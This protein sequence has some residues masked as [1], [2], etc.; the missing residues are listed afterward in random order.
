[1]PMR[2]LARRSRTATE[3]AQM[4]SGGEGGGDGEWEA[5]MVCP[6]FFT[7]MVSLFQGNENVGL[8][9]QFPS[10]CQNFVGIGTCCMGCSTYGCA[11]S[12]C[13]RTCC[14]TT[15]ARDEKITHM[16]I[17]ICTSLHLS[18]SG[19]FPNDFF[20]ISS[21]EIISTEALQFRR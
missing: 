7:T 14:C 17:G 21:V 16:Y 2:W 10:A 4:G 15:I 1:V 5:Q 9:N 6:N 13:V 3:E 18:R 20:Q 8:N 12:V 11:N 19:F